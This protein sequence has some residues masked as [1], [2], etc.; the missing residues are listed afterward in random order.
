VSSR[1]QRRDRA[2]RYTRESLI[3]IGKAFRESRVG[4]GFTMAGVGRVAG[5]SRWEIARYE[6]GELLNGT[7]L[8]LNRMA[9]ATGQRLS[10]KLYPDGDPVRDIASVRLLERLRSRLPPVFRWR[11][12]VPLHGSTGLRAWDAIVEAH[13]ERTAIEAETV[14]RDGQALQRRLR[15]KLRDDSTVS[16]LILLVAD[17]RGNRAALEAIRG[18]LR[19][20]FPLDTR[21]VLQALAQGR[22]PAANGLVIL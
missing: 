11:T 4:E 6:R 3:E 22:H 14:I 12:E 10:L 15:L 13:R 21:E 18:L 5:L 17:T 8:Q 7:L 19:D 20:T 2:D 16:Q 9:Q 1:E